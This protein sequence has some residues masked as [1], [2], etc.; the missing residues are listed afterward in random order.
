[1]LFPEIPDSFKELHR[2]ELPDATPPLSFLVF[3]KVERLEATGDA[4]ELR[5]KGMEALQR[6][7][8]YLA[9]SCFEQALT[10]CDDA[11][12]S[13]H[14]AFCM[15]KSG[16]DRQKALELAEKAH[17]DQPEN[18]SILL[19]LGRVQ[20]MAGSKE[21]GLTTLR[22]GV[23]LGGGKDFFAELGK[24]GTRTPPPIPSLPRTHPL[25]KYLGMMMYRLGLR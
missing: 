11:E 18:L 24:W 9:R 12:L 22:N 20:I 25:N 13:S 2:E 8:Y 14:L 6:K 1:V 21:Q 16:A 10:H 17:L 19:N 15:A 4:A 23:H 3:E 5:R 7:L